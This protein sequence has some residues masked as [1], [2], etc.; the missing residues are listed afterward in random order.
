LHTG[1]I[2]ITTVQIT[3]TQH[4]DLIKT[5][6]TVSRTMGHEEGGVGRLRERIPDADITIY[7]DGS[8]P[9]AIP[10]EDSFKA[11]KG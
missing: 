3:N 1:N 9:E 2:N 10:E 11:N 8:N 6:K 4:G 5:V 7:P